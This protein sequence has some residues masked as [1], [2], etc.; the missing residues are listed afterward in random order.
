MRKI[1]DYAVVT[2]RHES[3]LSD[4]VCEYMREYNMQ[5]F[6]SVAV[7]QCEN[8]QYTEYAQAMVEY[9]DNL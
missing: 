6:G 8:A 3:V 5:P 1:V 4:K 2:A 7:T 9:D